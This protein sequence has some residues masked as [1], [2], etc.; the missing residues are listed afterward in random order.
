MDLQY[1]SNFQDHAWIEARVIAAYHAQV[2]HGIFSRPLCIIGHTGIGKTQLIRQIAKKLGIGYLKLPIQFLDPPDLVGLQRVNEKTMRTEFAIPENI[3]LEGDGTTGIIDIP[4][5]NRVKKVMES[6]LYTLLDERVVGTRNLS[7]KWL[8]VCDANPPEMDGVTY[9]VR[10][11]DEALLGRVDFVTLVPKVEAWTKYMM[12]SHGPSC[13]TQFIMANPEALSFK[14][15]INTPRAFEA[16][17]KRLQVE[18]ALNADGDLTISTD[19]LFGLAAACIGH[20][21][22]STFKGFLNL[23]MYTTPAQILKGKWEE[24]KEGL[25]RARVD[26]KMEVALYLSQAVAD[27]YFYEKKVNMSNLVQFI[28]YLGEEKGLACVSTMLNREKEAVLSSDPKRGEITKKLDAL[29]QA[30]AAAKS[31][32]FTWGRLAETTK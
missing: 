14:A 10:E 32:V 18:N 23:R 30:C 15:G 26:G 22:A 12:N 25:E 2:N 8:I 5:L 13:V 24:A 11:F 29:K 1:L 9:D 3:P 17:Q 27:L 20:N 21:M 7:S 16:L 19:D 31:P 4:E 6:A 28:E